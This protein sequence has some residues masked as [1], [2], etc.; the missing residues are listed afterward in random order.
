MSLSTLEEAAKRCLNDTPRPLVIL[1]VASVAKSLINFRGKLLKEFLAKGCEVFVAAPDFPDNPSVRLMLESW[2]VYVRNVQMSRTGLSVTQDVRTFFELRGLL[3]EI[4]P[5]VFLGYTV[6]PVVYGLLAS[7]LQKTPNRVA[8][9]TGLGYAFTGKASGKRRLVQYL[10]RRLYSLALKQASLVFFQ[11]PDDQALFWKLNMLPN[12]VSSAVV[13]GS[14][15]DLDEFTPV[16]LPSDAV[17]FL[18]IGRLLA[19]KGIREYVAAARLVKKEYPNVEFLLVGGVDANPNSVSEA[20]L[21]DWV[22]DGV[23][24]YLGRIPDVRPAIRASSVYVLP[25]YREGTPRTTLEAMAMGRPVI[26][27]DAPGCRETVRDG[28][29]GY[30]VP[31]GSVQE[32]KDAMLNFIRDREKLVLM[33]D[34]SLTLVKEKYDVDYVNG[35][36]LAAMGF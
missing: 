18:L 20:E 35:K 9:I 5:D 16:P 27:T 34:N 3:K 1:V 10:V 36:M 32:L 29:N 4:S 7:S 17:R 21:N 33:G 31:V 30:L 13:N 28:F 19:D 11:N 24:N 6:K 2:G 26:T 22:D 15:V 23:V 14:G 25:S 8:L 12:T